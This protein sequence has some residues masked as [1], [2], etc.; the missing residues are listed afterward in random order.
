VFFMHAATLFDFVTSSYQVA[1]A[2]LN[3]LGVYNA[4]YVEG[5]SK[6]VLHTETFAGC[7]A[8]VAVREFSC[9]NYVISV[10]CVL[11]LR[12]HRSAIAEKIL[13]IVRTR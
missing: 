11:L 4:F 10:K 7:Y 9:V 13:T 3:H 12:K 5:S 2:I 6:K 1:F 8:K